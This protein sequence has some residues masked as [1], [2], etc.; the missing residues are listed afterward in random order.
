MLGLGNKPAK[1]Q[2][3]RSGPFENRFENDGPPSADV[4][5][6][7]DYTRERK[8]RRRKENGWHEH[9]GLPD[10]R[11]RPIHHELLM[12]RTTTCTCSRGGIQVLHADNAN[13]GRCGLAGTGETSNTNIVCIISTLA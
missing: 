13:G 9:D 6:A 2:S 1:L 7:Q 8:G 11:R 12:R 3:C 5:A 4:F 10:R